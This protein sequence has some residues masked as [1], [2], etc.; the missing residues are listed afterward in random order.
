MGPTQIVLIS[1]IKYSSGFFNSIMIFFI[2]CAEFNISLI[3]TLDTHKY[4]HE[5]NPEAR[6]KLLE[7][8]RD[9][10]LIDYYRILNPD[11]KMFT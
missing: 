10:G 11:K 7:I 8:M 3:Q 6:E 5:N 1:M 2:L 4:S 9:L